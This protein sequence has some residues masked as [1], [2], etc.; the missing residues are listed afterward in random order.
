[1]TKVNS[2]LCSLVASTALLGQTFSSAL[3]VTPINITVRSGARQTFQGLGFSSTVAGGNKY[4]QLTQSQKNTLQKLVCNDAKFKVVRLWFQAHKYSP[5]PGIENMP[6]FVNPYVKSGFIADAL[7]NGCTTLL[8]APDFLPPYMKSEDSAYIKDTEIFNYAA[9]LANF[10]YRMKQE[11]GVKIHATGI[12]NEPNDNPIKFK[13]SQWPVMITALRQELD[14]RNLKDVKIVTPELANADS[15]A[16]RIIKAIKNNPEAW[17]ALAAISTHSYNMAAAPWISSLLE[18]TDKEYW[19][20]EAGTTGPEEPGDALIAASGA[21][22]FLN[23]MNNRVTHWIWF[24]GHGV[25]HPED[26]STRLI[27]YTISPFKY[28]LFQKYHYFKQLT[29]TFDIGAVFRK[30]YS[31]LEKDMTWSSGKKPRIIVA[32]AKNPDGSWGIG[33]SNYTSDKFF[34]PLPAE[35]GYPKGTLVSDA[36]SGRA[37]EAFAVTVFIEE[38]AQAGDIKMKMYRSNSNVNNVYIGSAVM[39]K[40]TVTIPKVD[41]LDLITLRSL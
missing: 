27:P 15:I 38:L 39:R 13:D 5:Q 25:S 35:F 7:A 10:I 22:R 33:I 37:A 11:Y 20:T 41:S 21:S 8:L 3:A 32:S 28:Q 4:S 18:G 9:L 23:D 24:I 6:V 36:Q 12:L 30:S 2:L 29:R 40:G 19:I 14:N 1:M 31:S 26:N 34:F 16:V 17:K